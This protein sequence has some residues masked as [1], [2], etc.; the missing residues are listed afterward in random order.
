MSE[1][2]SVR[3]GDVVRGRVIE[4]RPFGILVDIGEA[5]SGLWSSQCLKTS[6]GASSAHTMTVLLVQETAPDGA[7]QAPYVFWK[8]GIPCNWYR[9]VANAGLTAH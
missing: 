8:C 9:A 2:S 1:R 7:G 6:L 4:H 5:Q 3:V